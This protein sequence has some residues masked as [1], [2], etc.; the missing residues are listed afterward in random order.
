MYINE[1]QYR[2]ARTHLVL[3]RA[4]AKV[5]D[6]LT[7]VLGPTEEQ[8]VAASGGLERELVEGQSLATGGLDASTG[9]GSEAEGRDVDLGDLEEAVV[10][11]DG[12]DDDNG[13]LLVILNVA[14]NARE[15]DGGAVDTGHKQAAEDDLVEARVG[16][17]CEGVR[18]WLVSHTP[19]I[20]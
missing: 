5:L 14:R 13:A 6:G 10:V 4:V 7:S 1:Q 15:G 3:V 20:G 12:A 2:R 9:G 17:A 11:G 19:N 8:R 16:A 18:A